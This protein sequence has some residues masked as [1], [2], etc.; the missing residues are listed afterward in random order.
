MGRLFKL[1]VALF[2]IGVA[3][4][5]IFASLS[6]YRVFAI[7]N[8]EDF[9]FVQLTYGEDEFTGLDLNFINR[10]YEVKVS[11]DN[12]IRIEYYQTDDE[13]I[14]VDET[15]N[16]LVIEH[17]M[18][19]FN[20][21]F[22]GLSF[23]INR[24]YF[25]VIVYLPETSLYQLSLNTSNGD[26]SISQMD[27]ITS[28]DIYTS[29][30]NIYFD[31]IV[32]DDATIHTSN[33]TV[34]LLEVDINNELVIHTSNGRITLDDVQASTIASYTSNG[35]IIASDI[36]SEDVILDTSNGRISL[37]IL[38][39]KA[40]YSVFLDTSNGDMIYDGLEVSQHSL[41]S[42]GQFSISINSSNG[43]V[44]VSFIN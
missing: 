32:L 24:S 28:L 38:G 44:E 27:V 3:S 33:G 21:M 31:S 16:D 25:K 2:I 29:N 35:K 14:S 18:S 7:S 10:A 39:K 43:D 23:L 41:N 36:V 30:G 9:E 26:V 11:E 12:L 4:I 42:D 5:V 1:S 6:E 17:D 34:N 40:D 8:D 37:E 15:Q 13:T 20:Q 19:W 22:T